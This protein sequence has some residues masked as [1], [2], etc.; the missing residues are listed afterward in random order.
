MAYAQLSEVTGEERHRTV[1][2]KVT[3]TYINDD[4]S[5]KRY[6]LSNYNI[7]AVSPVQACCIYMTTPKKKSL[8]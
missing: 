2:H 4:G 7:D 3:A 6:K 8:S 1:P 5:I